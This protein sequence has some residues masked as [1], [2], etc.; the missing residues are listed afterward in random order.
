MKVSIND[1]QPPPPSP[2]PV[3]PSLSHLLRRKAWSAA[4]RPVSTAATTAADTDEVNDSAF[5]DESV[6][7]TPNSHSYRC[8]CLLLL[9][10]NLSTNQWWYQEGYLN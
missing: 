3:D 4:T 8:I 5:A 1:M 7:P 2:R 9:I 10:V 6:S